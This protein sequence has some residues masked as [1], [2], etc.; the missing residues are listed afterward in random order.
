MNETIN[1]RAEWLEIEAPDPNHYELLGL[2]LFENDAERIRSNY[3]ERYARVRQYQVGKYSDEALQLLDE[4]SDAFQCLDDPQEKPK[5]DDRLRRT[6]AAKSTVLSSL[7]ETDSGAAAKAPVE[8]PPGAP[9]V[10]AELVSPPRPRRSIAARLKSIPLAFD[11]GLQRLL[12]EENTLLHYFAR[13][14]LYLA[15]PAALMVVGWQRLPD[16]LASA[17][18]GI[19]GAIALIESPPESAP[20]DRANDP[21][22]STSA[23]TEAPARHAPPSAKAQKSLSGELDALIARQVLDELTSE[24]KQRLAEQ[25]MVLADAPGADADRRFLLL[26]KA[27]RLAIDAEDDA[28]VSS[29]AAALDEEYDLGVSEVDEAWLRQFASSTESDIDGWET[30]PASFVNSVGMTLI[31]IPH[32]KFTMGSNDA[33]RDRDRDEVEHDVRITRPFYL[34]A[35]ETTQQEFREVLGRNPSW[36][37]PDHQGSEKVADLDTDRF[38]V[39]KV[40]WFDAVDFCNTLSVNEGLQPYYVLQGADRDGEGAI[41]D[42]TEVVISGGD[43]YR[44]PS[45]A[46][47]EYACRAGAATPFHFGSQLSGKEANTNGY[48]YGAAGAGPNLTR[49]TTVGSYSP[50]DFGLFDMHGNVWE[51]CQDWYGQDY[52]AGSP[53]DDP[54]G[55]DSG[56]FRVLRG[57]SWFNFPRNARAA[58]RFRSQPA[59]RDH[60]FGFRVAKNP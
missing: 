31:L 59:A 33:E 40:S 5:Y 53:T 32:G 21:G 56:T 43:G 35:Y 15:L 22:D 29:I 10:D 41:S 17:R 12:G 18:S 30:V 4:L 28:M 58:Y 50:N 25:V 11:R 47:W 2:P 48:S 49:T 36:F 27:A 20:G 8:P 45:E 44:L 51:W 39:E 1:P 38:P 14:M 34:A 9:I 57:G 6:L 23:S 42:V 54:T 55:P 60:N 19:D 26:V 7:N 52:Y 24:Q 3:L 37:S 13:V 46:E 16:L